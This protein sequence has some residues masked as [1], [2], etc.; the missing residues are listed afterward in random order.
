MD[1]SDPAATT[2]TGA[3]AVGTRLRCPTCGS[4]LIVVTKAEAELS[5]CGRPPVAVAPPKR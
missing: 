3:L 5:C 2:L 4:E 1:A